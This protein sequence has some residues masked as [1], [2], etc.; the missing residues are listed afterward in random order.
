MAFTHA[1]L[2]TAIQNWTENDATEFTDILNDVIFLA[3]ERIFRDAD[4][5]AF[6]CYATTSLT[7][8]DKYLNKPTDFVFDRYIE[9]TVA[10][11]K[12]RLLQRDTSFIHQYWPDDTVEGVPKY[13]ADWDEDFFVIAPTPDSGYATEVAYYIHPAGLDVASPTTTWLSDEAP[14]LLLYA[15]LVEANKFIKNP[16]QMQVWEVSYQ[17]A[18]QRV[19]KDE[20]YRQRRDEWRSGEIRK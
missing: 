15:C 12:V 9:I 19:T 3:E 17:Q 13:Y 14:D 11:D 7:Q 18:L 4:L 2:R 6:R 5:D 20:Q 10:G 16:E 1:T 8:G